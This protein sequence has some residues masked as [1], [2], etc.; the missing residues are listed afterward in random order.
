MLCEFGRKVESKYRVRFWKE[1]TFIIG[2]GEASYST[3]FFQFLPPEAFDHINKIDMTF[4]I[5]DLGE[6]RVQSLRD[7][8][9]NP[10]VRKLLEEPIERPKKRSSKRTIKAPPADSTADNTKKHDQAA[11][12]ESSEEEE[13]SSEDPSAE[14]ETAAATDDDTQD[15]SS[16]QEGIPITPAQPSTAPLGEAEEEATPRHHHDLHQ[17]LTLDLE[18]AWTEKFSTISNLP[19]TA[20]TLDFSECYGP[21]GDWLGTDLAR[22]FPALEKGWPA[23]F[24]IHAP[25]RGKK[26]E[27]EGAMLK[28]Y[29]DSI[30][31]PDNI[32]S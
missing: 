22:S 30:P 16:S 4:T 3:D 1:N 2:L 24:M 25:D 28:R 6:W 21:A 20:L 32:D 31:D 17:E 15:S 18:T 23:V 13:E 14:E 11:A 12:N 26:E 8:T 19:L 9:T 5:R 10:F 7:S 27:I 29:L